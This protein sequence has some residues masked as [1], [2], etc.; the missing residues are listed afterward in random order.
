M[1][2]KLQQ[3]NRSTL[4]TIAVIVA[5][6]LFLSVNLI[7]SLAFETAR[8]D[9]TE[10]QIYKVSDSTRAVLESVDQPI[11][12][13]LYLSSG[14]IAE[15][16][17]ARVYADR[18]TEMLRTYEQLSGGLVQFEQIDPVPFST[19]EDRAIGYN[20][21]SLNLSRAGEQGYFGLV[22]TNTV[23]QLEVIRLVS[24][25]REAYLEYDLTRMV[26]RLASPTEPKI[27][28][29]DGLSLFG[30]V[31]LGR[32]PAAMIER[33]GDDF[34]LEQMATD[35]TIIPDDIDAL[36][37]IHPH[38]L[39]PSA[40]YAIDQYVIR[41]GPVLVFLDVVAEH[42]PP[43][44]T[45]RALPQFPDS[46]LEPLLTAWGVTMLPE[47]VVG[48]MDMALEVRGE[49]GDQIVIAEYPPWLIVD[50]DNLNRDDVITAQLSLMRISSAGTLQRLANA[51]TVITPLIQTTPESMLYEQATIMRRFDP[52]T[53]I[54]MFEPS[55]TRQ[56]VAARI[57]GPVE[58]AFPEG[59]PP[60][61]EPR[62]D[63]EAPPEPPELIT[64]SVGSIAVVIVADTDMLANDHN[65][66]ES[67]G[68]STQNSDFVVN[69]LDSLIG[70]TKL[71][72]LRGLGL[73][74]R[75]FTRVD[76][77]EAAAEQ[78]YFD[79]EQ[80]LQAELDEVEERLT[81]LRAPIDAEG[82]LGALTRQQQEAI[83]EFNQ[84]SIELRQ[85][86]R[87]V[88]GA[89][90][91]EIDSLDIWLKLI[92]ILAVPIIVVIIGVGV[93]V[94][95]DIRLAHYLRGRQA[96]AGGA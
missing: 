20:L 65:V 8:I 2:D 36:V 69:A 15:E 38:N 33:L 39:T 94:W 88:R 70:G 1:W 16:P 91:Q 84:R 54:T 49:A 64:Q 62:E 58:T 30:S 80:R 19:A 9:L 77:F 46:T 92:N 67:G 29:F 71:I 22:G 79:T 31:A 37:I 34:E 86:L 83:T 27:G 95:R 48:D 26:A 93:F 7:A 4:A 23:D 52:T 72:G 25:A 10:N 5:V 66:A 89:L 63:E 41:G 60:P 12:L 28:V 68:Q 47:L 81:E 90:R 17:N 11:N 96:T 35:V 61:P 6:V 76:E 43:S 78:V 53:L 24:P 51:T 55:G 13:R 73:V 14:L 32:F 44:P 50:Q 82:Q 42:S 40:L 59:A 3:L 56:V 87:D 18:V 75:P 85:E 57:V 74:F 21:F 45:N